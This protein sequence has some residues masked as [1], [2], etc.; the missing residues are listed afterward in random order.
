MDE[1]SYLENL[2]RL[3]QKNWPTVVHRNNQYPHGE[4]PIT[5]YLRI[6]AKSH[7]EKVAYIFY[8]ALLTFGELNSLSERFAA[9]LLAH[10]VK[11]GD[12]V[13]VFLPNIPQFILAFY[14]I[15]KAGAVHVP[16]N[17]MFK[18]EELV[19]ELNDTAAG[20]LI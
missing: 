4:I 5:E 17:P 16:V 20:V 14:G 2:R 11:K 7:P 18:A 6:R 9:V 13:A 3:W 1:R 19:H 10:G 12:R 8:G 15:L